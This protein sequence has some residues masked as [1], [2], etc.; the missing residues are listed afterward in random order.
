MSQAARRALKRLLGPRWTT[1]VRCFVRGHDRPRWGN[2]R[3]VAPFSVEFGFDRGTPIDRYYL[4]KFLDRHRPLITGEVLEIQTVAYAERYGHDVR[5]ADS[6]DVNARLHPTFLCD[7]ARSDDVLP[8]EQ[9]DCFL[10]PNTLQHLR[11]LDGCLR[12]AL[13]VVRPGG[14]V[15]ASAAGFVPLIPDGPDYWRLSADGWAELLRRRWAGCDVTVESHGNCLAGVAAMLGLAREELT[16]AELDVA[17]PR[18]PV[19]VTVMCRKPRSAPA[20]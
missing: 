9:Y 5:R 13:R 15:L 19:L 20:R 3:R 16:S 6:V 11:D 12:H 4:E 8:S 10:L 1:R 2:L 18:Y 7:L 17:D 14:V